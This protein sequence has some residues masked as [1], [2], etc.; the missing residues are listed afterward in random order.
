MKSSCNTDRLHVSLAG[1][2]DPWKALTRVRL[3]LLRALHDG[4][5][6]S[7]LASAAGR[8]SDLLCREL[9]PLIEVHLLHKQGERYTP[10]FFIADAAET[11]KVV[12]HAQQL[13]QT[14]ADH[15]T[16]HWSRLD[17]EFSELN[18]SQSHSIRDLSFLLVGG[19]ILDIGLLEALKRDRTLLN[20]APARP[21]LDHPEAQFYFYMI[22]G[23]RSDLGRYG[24]NDTTL[25]WPNWY[26]LTFG[27]DWV[28]GAS[29]SE[30]STLEETCQELIHTETTN[31]PEELAER[32]RIPIF[33]ESDTSRWL[34]LVHEYSEILLNTYLAEEHNLKRLYSTLRAS[35]YARHGFSEFFCWYD[36]VAYAYAIDA[37]ETQ[38][39]IAIPPVRFTAALW[40][41]STHMSGCI[42]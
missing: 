17:A 5:T 18:V 2:G 15:L 10:T 26:L 33:T 16:L 29:N 6:L 38:G 3:G 20:P 40:C 24:L 9:D 19:Q 25:P 21:S 12:E 41:T 36:H 11:R 30:R 13:G 34:G 7:D 35:S 42:L 22:E 4:R 14:L 23:D 39:L 1:S 28:N 37:L 32:L 31:N 8:P 27:Q